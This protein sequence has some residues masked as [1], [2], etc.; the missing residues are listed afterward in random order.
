MLIN[1]EVVTTK[2]ANRV[3]Y[4]DTK[5]GISGIFVQ[6]LTSQGFKNKQK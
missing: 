6:K 2:Y 3:F 1:D 5:V 4:N